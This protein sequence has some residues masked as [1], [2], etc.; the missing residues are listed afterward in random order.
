M[1]TTKIN[2]TKKNAVNDIRSLFENAKD[3]L[4]TDFRGLS[5]A[6]IAALRNTLRE[7]ATDYK[8]VK[9]NYTKIAMEE[10]GLPDVSDFLF[11][12]TALALTK[13]DVGPVAKVLLD[14]GRDTSVAI[15][16][17]VVGGKVF[18]L[19]EVKALSALPSRE[20]LLA[21]LMGTMNAPLQNLAGCLNGI[22]QKLVRT[23][24]AI[25]EK[26]GNEG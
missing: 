8:V 12:P 26:K 4:F 9:N 19:D 13:G 5:V 15:K 20:Q 2:E 24:Q 7:S 21:M 25:A 14:F 16:G 18:S 17:G 10:L 22:L 3:V 1:K 23:L 6:E 11:G